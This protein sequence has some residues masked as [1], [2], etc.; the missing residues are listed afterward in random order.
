MID[1]LMAAA[2]FVIVLAPLVT[3]HEFGHFIVAKALKIGVPVFSI[4]FG[5]RLFGVIRG[6]TDYRVSAVPLG[7][8]VRLAGDEADENRTGGPDEFLTRARWQRFLVFVAGAA[9]NIAFAVLAAALMFKVYGKP[10]PVQ[11]EAY[12][13]VA[14]LAAGSTA[15]AAGVRVGDRIVSVQGRDARQPR[16]LGE[17][18]DLSPGTVKE[19]V[20]ER[21]GE[22]LTI[23]MNT[24]QDERFHLGSPGW[25]LR[26][27][28][29]GP[30]KIGFVQ[31]GAPA[32]KA[33]L[34]TGDEILALD[35]SDQLTDLQVRARLEA[36]AGR[37]VV[38]KIRRDGIERDMPVVPQDTDG[39]GKI[40]V[41]FVDGS[42]VRRPV[43]VAGA[44]RAS[45]DHNLELARGLFRALASWGERLFAKRDVN[46]MRMFS[47]PIEIA[48]FSKMALRDAEAFLGFMTLLSLNLGIINLMPIPVLD[49]GHILIL[50]VEGL[51]RRDLSM[52]VKE[53]VM[54]AG[55]VFLLAFFALV[56]F[57][58]IRKSL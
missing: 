58:D 55:F 16:A 52:K 28:T 51:I 8:Y 5:P 20:V 54:Q 39:K 36:S 11:P 40:G 30:P 22:R 13:V 18:I 19:V 47:G 27:Q 6:G 32:E 45:V 2:A 10:E 24:G 34:R 44:F 3:V 23:S 26:L 25:E 41:T 35:G 37:E 42:I 15:Q 4:G 17:E 29:P 1:F 7:G 33:G 49:G 48:S 43:S 56:I 57:F 14:Q 21:D 31:S 50:T 38:L 53:R 46:A 12:P 9:F